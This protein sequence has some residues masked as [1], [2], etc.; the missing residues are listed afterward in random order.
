MSPLVNIGLATYS[1]NTDQV[2][3]PNAVQNNITD[4]KDSLRSEGGAAENTTSALDLPSWNTLHVASSEPSDNGLHLPDADGGDE[5]DAD[6]SVDSEFFRERKGPQI[7]KTTGPVNSG[8]NSSSELFTEPEFSVAPSTPPKQ[9]ASVSRVSRSPSKFIGVVIPRSAHSSPNKHTSL[10]T[11]STTTTLVPNT[12]R[13]DASD[14]TTVQQHD[15]DVTILLPS[16]TKTPGAS[17]EVL[18]HTLTTTAPDPMAALEEPIVDH[19]ESLVGALT[20]AF[21]QNAK[22]NSTFATMV[23]DVPVS[24]DKALKIIQVTPAQERPIRA[25]TKVQKH[26]QFDPDDIEEWLET[27]YAT[28]QDHS[29]IPSSKELLEVTLEALRQVQTSYGAPERTQKWWE[30]DSKSL[31]ENYLSRVGDWFGEEALKNVKPMGRKPP[32]ASTKSAWSREISMEVDTPTNE[33]MG[34]YLGK[35]KRL[36][37]GTDK[38]APVETSALLN[39]KQDSLDADSDTPRTDCIETMERKGFSESSVSLIQKLVKGKRAMEQKELRELHICLAD[40]K[41]AGEHVNW[42]GNLGKVMWDS[43]KRL[44]SMEDAPKRLPSMALEI[45]Q[46]W[47]ARMG[48]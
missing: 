3:T 11:S 42:T 48:P 10:R 30:N 46:Y 16:G 47:Q 19:G 32:R 23:K 2:H 6:G 40:I 38:Q 15:V 27:D 21:S 37:D 39:N 28:V 18:P 25:R 36:D 31:T 26:V 45:C 24:N 33:A 44:S 17:V 43:L 7:H 8:R 41:R 35:R 12:V 22:M 29:R 1:A 5:L 4:T 14:T 13:D 20:A 34:T 9:A